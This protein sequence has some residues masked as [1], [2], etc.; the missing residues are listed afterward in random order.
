M[1]LLQA[2]DAARAEFAQRVHG[3]AA[4]QWTTAT[5]CTEWSVRDLVNHVVGE[6]LWAPPLLRGATL[7]E[8]GD[9]FGG[10]VLGDHPTR[11]WDRSAEQSAAAFHRDGALDGTVQTGA[12]PTPATEYGWQMTTD[13]AVHAWDL[14]RGTG[15]DEP[16]D[17]ALAA[18]VL[19]FVE[20]Q[21][22]A[23][24]G[25]GVF[26][27]PVPVPASASAQDR[28]VALLGRRP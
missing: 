16:L 2:F 15:D 27:P 21:A 9:R 17:E 18:A 7:A 4:G 10:D 24:Q 28:L 3:V 8:V 6:Q 14:G 13:L 12:G 1:E 25:A 22:A 5:P 23:W 20:P 19:A 11:A 26:A